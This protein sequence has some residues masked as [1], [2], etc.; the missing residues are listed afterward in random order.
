MRAGIAGVLEQ[1]SSSPPNTLAEHLDRLAAACEAI[2]GE[3][4]WLGEGGDELRDAFDLLQ[5]ES[6]SLSAM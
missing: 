5:Q 4:F 1:L 2:A 3:A 6:R